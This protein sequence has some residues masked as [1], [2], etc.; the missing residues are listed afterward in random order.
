MQTNENDII[1]LGI[2]ITITFLLL[3]L[4]FIF[5]V[6]MFQKNMRRKQQELF[7]SVLETQENERQRIGKDLHDDMGPLLSAIKLNIDLLCQQAKGSPQVTESLNY[8]EKLIDEAVKGIRR[9]SH[10]LMPSVLYTYGLHAALE[11]FCRSINNAG[12]VQIELNNDQFPRVLPPGVNLNLYRI[13]QEFINNSLK[14]SGAK[15]IKIDLLAPNHS[16]VIKLSDNGKGLENDLKNSKGIGIKN[17]ESRI[18][19]LSAKYDWRSIPGKGLH[20]KIVLTR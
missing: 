16:L 1:Q 17:I 3:A 7:Q 9:A 8:T 14:H 5:L 20:L 6:I 10:E 19:L 13:I 2:V 18:N 12:K 11:E 4:F 15:K